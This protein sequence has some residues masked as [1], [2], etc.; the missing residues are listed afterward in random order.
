MMESKRRYLEGYPCI[1]NSERRWYY[2]VITKGLFSLEKGES[3]PNWPNL[4]GVQLSKWWFYMILGIYRFGVS[5]I[6][7]PF[8][9]DSFYNPM[10][11]LIVLT[12]DVDVFFLEIFFKPY[13][14]NITPWREFY[15]SNSIPRHMWDITSYSPQCT[16]YF[17]SICG[18]SYEHIVCL[19]ISWWAKSVVVCA[20]MY[21]IEPLLYFLCIG[22]GIYSI[23]KPRVVSHGPSF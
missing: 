13:L 15:S 16:L 21:C 19:I 1:W 18:P 8:E 22:G 14:I 17:C 10:L 3:N 4:E 6:N 2:G 20:L 9:F 12:R 7:I 11:V 5:N 23:S